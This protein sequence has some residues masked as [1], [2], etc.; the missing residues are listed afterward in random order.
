[1]ASSFDI[2]AA[3]QLQAPTNID[4]IASS[5]QSKLTG[6]KANIDIGIPPGASTRITNLNN[7]LK[8][9]IQNL[10]DVAQNATSAASAIQA[11]GASLDGTSTRLSNLQSYLKAVSAGFVNIGRSVLPASDTI[12]KFGQQ[13]ALAARRFSAFTVAAGAIVG[14]VAGIKTG[15]SEAINF[16]QQIVKIGQITQ[17]STNNL[18]PLVDEVTRLGVTFGVSSKSLIEISNTLAQAGLSAKDTRAALEA[19]AKTTLAPTF[20]DI[21]N[22]TE[23][24]ISSMAQFN[25]AASDFEKVFGSINSVAAAFAV[26]AQDL[27]TVITKTGGVFKTL[28]GDI[29]SPITQL[30]QLISLFTS[31]RQTTRESADT[32]ATGFR[33]IFGRLERPQTLQFLEAMG[34]KLTDLKGNFIGVFPAVREL[35]RA[36]SEI[37]STSPEY[38][39]IVEQI[40]G[41]RQISKVIPLIQQF[42]VALRALQVAQAGQ[43]SLTVDASRSQEAFAQRLSKVKEEFLDL[44]RIISRNQ[45]FTALAD[46][47]L[48]T[49]TAIAQI[50]KALEPLI[51]LMT[52]YAAIKFVPAAAQF[53]KGFFNYFTTQG[54]AHRAQGGEIPHFSHGG[55]VPGHGT[56]DTVP[57]MLEPKEFVI[58]QSSTA[59]VAKNYP[60]VLE[61]INKYGVL[62]QRKTTGDE[63]SKYLQKLQDSTRQSSG[64]EIEYRPNELRDLKLLRSLKSRLSPVYKPRK[65][66]PKI[67][68]EDSLEYFNETGAAKHLLETLNDDPKLFHKVRHIIPQEARLIG[69]GRIAAAFGIPNSNEVFRVGADVGG[70]SSGKFSRTDSPLVVQPN[71]TNRL[72]PVIV[73]RLPFAQSLHDLGFSRADIYPGDESSIGSRVT[74]SLLDKF[75]ER[76]KK[77]GLKAHDIHSGNIGFLGKRLMAIDP[78]AVK[79]GRGDI[80]G[81]DDIN[82]FPIQYFKND[83]IKLPELSSDRIL[84]R[85]ARTIN[86]LPK[87][88]DHKRLLSSLS[89]I[90]LYNTYGKINA[91][92]RGN[93]SPITGEIN[94]NLSYNTLAHEFTHAY[95]YSKFFQRFRTSF[96]S[97]NLRQIVRKLAKIDPVFKE[98]HYDYQYA[99]YL[100]RPHEILARGVGDYTEAK[101]LGGNSYAEEVFGRIRKQRF[102]RGDS[103]DNLSIRQRFQDKL[104]NQRDQKLFG[105]EIDFG[106]LLND[107]P[108]TS[109][110]IEEIKG[111]GSTPLR[112]NLQ[113]LRSH[114][115]PTDSDSEKTKESSK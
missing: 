56:G 107:F 69:T 36:L 20:G 61:Y 67:S 45:V 33:T 84:G 43:N 99:Q 21:K 65:T 95:D 72:G 14:V 58:K 17:Q 54:V 49:A 13:S 25:I 91:T 6:I 113:Q 15:L 102:A 2:N 115:K 98:K 29:D 46:G 74:G 114:L 48:R 41:L 83:S 10:K 57:A 103:V 81:L 35:N 42:P 37:P 96:E 97:D 75:Y 1:M 38:A 62:P 108:E 85:I 59:K 86:N 31:V 82:Q 22:T 27:T 50:T 19:L 32:I 55:Y 112:G 52:A 110:L 80:V 23:A 26:E 93:F 78:D 40:G 51:P 106:D 8:T 89:N 34:V 30:N 66:D 76:A 47:F 70:R 109:P 77:T 28:S 68:F 3:I 87:L 79:Y 39:K 16:Q 64:T 94:S 88:I 60:G 105:S 90:N 12:E 100:E 11:I 7:R 104:R 71:K 53:G 18:K 73:E 63:I 44:F 92:Q 24:A 111:V 9:L 101:I 4:S 5:I